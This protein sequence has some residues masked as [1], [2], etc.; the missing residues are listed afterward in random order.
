MREIW[1]GLVVFGTA[2][3]LYG[4]RLQQCDR[5]IEQ[6]TTRHRN[7]F[8]R[9]KSSYSIS[10]YEPNGKQQEGVVKKPAQKN[11]I[12]SI[13]LKLKNTSN[14]VFSIFFLMSK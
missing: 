9:K 1:Y 7:A 12:S 2:V 5:D 13:L 8:F 6:W 3:H 11:S 14:A 10:I 4:V